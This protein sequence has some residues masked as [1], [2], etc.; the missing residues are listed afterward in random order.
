VEALS[1]E[2]VEQLLFYVENRNKVSTRNKLIVYLLLYTDVR[3]SE[4][5]GIKIADVDFLT[6]QLTVIG[7]GGKRREIG[8]RQDVLQLVRD[9]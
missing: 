6:S 9:T 8:L 5:V 3:V 4:L 1:D 7:K 2:K